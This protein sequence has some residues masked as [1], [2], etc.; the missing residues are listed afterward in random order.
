MLDNLWFRVCLC[1]RWLFTFLARQR[2]CWFVTTRKPKV[3]HL[4]RWTLRH[5]KTS[6]INLLSSI[7]QLLTHHEMPMKVRSKMSNTTKCRTVHK[8]TRTEKWK[9]FQTDETAKAPLLIADSS[10]ASSLSPSNETSQNCKEK[11]LRL[12]M[13]HVCSRRSANTREVISLCEND[14]HAK[15][16]QEESVEEEERRKKPSLPILHADVQA[17]LRETTRIE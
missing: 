10:H 3:H 5:N 8:T 9:D 13:S 7:R 16:Q 4:S 17:A 12:F 2:N 6:S 15:K 1:C 14:R 11:D